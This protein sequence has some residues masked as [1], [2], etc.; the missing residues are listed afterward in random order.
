MK[1]ITILSILYILSFTYPTISSAQ[2]N[3]WTV[4]T[5]A[6]DTL[7]SCIVVKLEG[8]V[9]NLFCGSSVV[10]ISVDSLSML[11]RHKESHFWSGAGY[12]TL[13]GITVGAIVG[14]ATYHKPTGAWD[15]DLGPGV[16]ALGGG[17]LGAVTGFTIGGI[18]GAVSGGDEKYDLSQEPTK[19]KIKILRDLLGE[20][21]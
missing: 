9:V 5:S 19:E 15:I 7:R 14:L 8:D 6:Q 1:I 16:A 11:I 20:N 17:I 2:T 18:V 10:Q 21:R 4:I 13:A 3:K 12:G